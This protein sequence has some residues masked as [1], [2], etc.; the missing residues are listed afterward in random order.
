MVEI[1]GEK[2]GPENSGTIAMI[3][4]FHR[5]PLFLLG[6]WTPVFLVWLWVDSISHVRYLGYSWESGST[7]YC[8]TVRTDPHSLCLSAARLIERSL[9]TH[10]RRL[11][12]ITWE[13]AA[14]PDPRPVREKFRFP[15]AYDQ[16]WGVFGL[17]IDL[18][19]ALFL[20]L[21][22]WLGGC[23]WWRRRKRRLELLD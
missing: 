18:W 9:T 11:G 22:L 15:V 16:G 1:A 13:D 14:R 10:S 12:I 5:S 20:Y 17:T 7:Y 6:A 21:G 4:P 8:V 23:W 19:F 3:R 2:S